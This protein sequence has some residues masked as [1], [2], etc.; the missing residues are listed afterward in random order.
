MMS[1]VLGPLLVIIGA[2]TATFSVYVLWKT[3]RKTPNN[4]D[5]PH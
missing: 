2:A 3:T 4:D 1:E 5:K